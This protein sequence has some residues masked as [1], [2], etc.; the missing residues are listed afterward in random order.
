VGVE[1]CVDGGG[2]GVW[3]YGVGGGWGDGCGVSVVRR[4][5]GSGATGWA[6]CSGVGGQTVRR[7]PPR[8]LNHMSPTPPPP[9][10]FSLVPPLTLYQQTGRHTC[11]HRHRSW[12]LPPPHLQHPATPPPPPTPLR[13]PLD[14]PRPPVRARNPPRPSIHPPPHDH[15]ARVWGGGGGGLSRLWAGGDALGGWGGEVARGDGWVRGTGGG[16]GGSH[17]PPPPLAQRRS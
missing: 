6:G 7:K 5:L 8:Y 10:F 17:P 16:G 11:H 12:P 2:G 13:P 3:G 4:G 9:T 1:G 14:S 15:T